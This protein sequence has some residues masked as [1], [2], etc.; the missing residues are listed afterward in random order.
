VSWYGFL[1][2]VSD[3]TNTYT[4]PDSPSQN[5]SFE[6]GRVLSF[7]ANRLINKNGKTIG[8]PAW[9]KGHYSIT[10]GTRLDP[11]GQYVNIFPAQGFNNQFDVPEQSTATKKAGTGYTI[12][13]NSG[14]TKWYGFKYSVYW[15]STSWTADYSNTMVAPGQQTTVL[16]TDLKDG[17]GL[18]IM[19]QSLIPNQIPQPTLVVRA[20]LDGTWENADIW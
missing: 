16:D 2:T 7:N 20:S 17:G 12:L 14:D 6:P 15:N 13:T 8:F 9:R 10:M 5:L 3:G 18:T 4:N 1:A 11:D 19:Q